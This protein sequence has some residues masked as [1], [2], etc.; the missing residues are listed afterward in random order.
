VK[1]TA[2]QK[3]EYIWYGIRLRRAA[4]AN[5]VIDMGTGAFIWGF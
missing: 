5:V 4:F 2:A 1:G 3:M